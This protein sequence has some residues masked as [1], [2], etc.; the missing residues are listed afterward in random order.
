M[1]SKVRGKHL[2]VV[3]PVLLI[4]LLSAIATA[5]S[6]PDLL[7]NEV[8]QVI[9]QASRFDS[10]V[11]SDEFP[12]TIQQL[13]MKESAL[14]SLMGQI[15]DLEKALADSRKELDELDIR[16]ENLVE[17]LELARQ[18]LELQQRQLQYW[19][20]HFMRLQ[21]DRNDQGNNR[22][23]SFYGAFNLYGRLPFGS[24]SRLYY[25]FYPQINFAGS[26][27]ISFSDF[28]FQLDPVYIMGNKMRLEFGTYGIPAWSNLTV[29]RKYRKE[30][31]ERYTTY[32]YQGAL[33]TGSPRGVNSSFF[34][35]KIARGIPERWLYGSRFR[36]SFAQ[37]QNFNI[38]LLQQKTV[39]GEGSTASLPEATLLSVELQGSQKTKY[40]DFNYAVETAASTYDSD[41]K[42][43]PER[44]DSGQGV[45]GSLTWKRSFAKSQ[46]TANLK[47][48][49][50]TP[51]YARSFVYGS[52]ALGVL[53]DEFMDTAY[54]YQYEENPWEE[55]YYRNQKNITLTVDESK[56]I[57]YS[58][59]QLQL[60]RLSEIQKL[61]GGKQGSL[62]GLNLN[63]DLGRFYP[64]SLTN[65]TTLAAAFE[66]YWNGAEEVGTDLVMKRREFG[67]TRRLS[68]G[69]TI[70]GEIEDRLWDGF[71]RGV[72]L[73]RLERIFRMELHTRLNDIRIE[74]K[75][76][77][78]LPKQGQSWQRQDSHFH[79]RLKIWQ[80][81]GSKT[82]LEGRYELWF[83]PSDSTW[84]D[85]VY[86]YYTMSL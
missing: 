24:G 20:N 41:T 51:S 7:V 2:L 16:V 34:A 70:I 6:Q 43:Q 18:K 30:V 61:A 58:N 81:F 4:S 50:I 32:Q 67:I 11:N 3:L 74:N 47:I 29:K 49:A 78:T 22:I 73:D 84:R 76:E 71:D 48:S 55:M 33:L 26:N 5:A 28:S 53:S 17:G 66:R 21:I 52:E 85:Q 40:G 59:I 46:G 65:N 79:N 54:L 37:N 57:P 38:V 10:Q 8:Y 13:Q 31:E 64:N 42:V 35:G 60:V 72:G 63:F 83:Y 27:S 62:A 25:K 68:G 82:R 12:V 9:A 75:A 77:Y 45:I 86:L 69:A 44:D 19:G 14:R 39:A 56:L 15:D 36:G 1:R 80:S 23:S